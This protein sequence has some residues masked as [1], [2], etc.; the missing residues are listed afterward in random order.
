MYEGLINCL[1]DCMEVFSN[2][3]INAE[4][5]MSH[6]LNLRIF[7]EGDVPRIP[8]KEAHAISSQKVEYCLL[9]YLGCL[10][11]ILMA[12]ILLLITSFM[13]LNHLVYGWQNS[14]S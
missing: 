7:W 10:L 13:G 4:S 9:S 6:H 14:S 12:V 5:R 11:E 2:D 1:I 8:L 3:C